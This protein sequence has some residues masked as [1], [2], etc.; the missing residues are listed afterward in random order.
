[1]QNKCKGQ[2][3]LHPTIGDMTIA[4]IAALEARLQAASVSSGSIHPIARSLGVALT[5]LWCGKANVSAHGNEP[6][7]RP[8]KYGF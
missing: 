7:R 1:M 3:S 8:F 6:D 2:Q 4:S 5:A